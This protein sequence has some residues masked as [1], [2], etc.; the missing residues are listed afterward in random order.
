MSQFIY[1]NSNEAENMYDENGRQIFQMEIDVDDETHPLGNVTDFDAYMNEKPVEKPE[2]IRG[3]NLVNIKADDISEEKKTQVYKTYKD[4]EKEAFFELYYN[5]GMSARAAAIQLKIKIRTA[6]DWA[7]KDQTDPQDIIQRKIGSGKPVG[8]PSKFNP[9]H[10]KYLEDLVDE[11][12]DIVLG[13][14]MTS[15]VG[16]FEGLKISQTALHSYLKEKCC[17]TLKRAR[18][19]SV[20]RNSPEKI[21][22][23]FSWIK[24]WLQTDMDYSSNC[25][26]IDESAFHINLK[27]SYA[28]SKKGTPA[29][30]KVP[31]TRAKT[32]TIM[33]AIS[34]KGVVKVSVRLPKASANKKRKIDDRNKNTDSR[35]GG[36]KSGHYFN[37][38]KSC[39]DVMDKHEEFKGNYLVM[40]NAP[41]HKNEDI[42]NYIESRGY[43]CIYLP[44][45]SPEL[46]P[47]E[48]FWSVC[49]SKIK[50]HRLLDEETLTTRI[51]DA[52][53]QVLISDIQGFCRSSISHF[54][55]CL[56]RKEL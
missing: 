17:V 9:E 38:I 14:I 42:Q 25:V 15:L 36:T 35:G 27:R 49:K 26:F 40:D 53:N 50:K 56:D 2:K 33:G 5:K 39:L 3:D 41:I 23:R 1:H 8:R 54:Q 10:K 24:R 37:F 30:V 51:R 31:K 13:D 4:G 46:N 7:Q 47:I 19:H 22:E 34:A 11:Q 16:R 45:Y 43:G 48:Q 52:S 6:Q 20:E 18:F 12:P 29:I 44:P 55:D 21:E 28:R 32:T